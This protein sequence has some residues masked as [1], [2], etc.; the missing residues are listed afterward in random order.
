MSG[1]CPFPYK[2]APYENNSFEFTLDPYISYPV[3]GKLAQEKER[4]P[5][6]AEE[7]EV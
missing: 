7:K 2:M 5:N 4:D 3:L 6:S 1:E